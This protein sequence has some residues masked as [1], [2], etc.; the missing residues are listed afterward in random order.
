MKTKETQSSMVE[1]FAK[2]VTVEDHLMDG[3]FGS[4]LLEATSIRPDLLGRLK[5][6]SLDAKICGMVGKQSTLNA[7]GGLIE[8]VLCS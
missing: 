2:V 3:G 1:N 7:E 6:K 5:I 4:W 8:E